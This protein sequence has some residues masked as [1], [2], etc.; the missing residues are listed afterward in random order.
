MLFENHLTEHLKC[1]DEALA[2]NDELTARKL[3]S[4]LEERWPD[5]QVSLATIKRVRKA[6]S[7]LIRILP[8]YSCS[9]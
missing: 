9:Q 8:A 3:R 5:L 4:I 1:M 6:G 7:V 2:S